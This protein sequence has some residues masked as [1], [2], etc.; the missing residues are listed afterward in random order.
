MRY[1]G[2]IY[3]DIGDINLKKGN[4]ATALQF[5]HKA[6]S[7]DI[8]SH[9]LS[10]QQVLY[11]N[12]ADYFTKKQ[13]RDSSLFYAKKSLAAAILFKSVTMGDAYECL[14][15]SYRLNGIIDSAYK[16]QGLA[17]IARDSSNKTD[18]KNLGDFEKLSMKRQL[19][20][21]QLQKEKEDT[22][23]WIRTCTLYSS[24]L[25]LFCSSL[26]SFTGTAAKGKKPT[27][28]CTSKRKK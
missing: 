5:Y 6:I 27:T 18:L 23:A 14:Y 17:L 4:E 25:L 11:G 16:Y 13:Q 7:V 22:E 20:L 15:K 1:L 24:L 3:S 26:F 2:F 10:E 9:V 28:C 21:Q 19:S 12:L 8:A